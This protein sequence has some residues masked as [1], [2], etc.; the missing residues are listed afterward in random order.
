MTA[1]Q[2]F[3]FL[4][5]IVLASGTCFEA[6]RETQ[7]PASLTRQQFHDNCTGQNGRFGTLRDEVTCSLTPEVAV[8]CQFASTLGNCV[9]SGP[10]EL[11]ALGRLFA[12]TRAPLP[13]G[14]AAA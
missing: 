2:P 14:G 11:G 3:L 7:R 1:P 13:A 10:I 4:I 12:V 6:M 9:W 8:V 5:A